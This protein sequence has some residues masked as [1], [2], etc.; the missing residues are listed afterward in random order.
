MNHPSHHAAP[1]GGLAQGPDF[2][3]LGNIAFTA[4]CILLIASAV[5]VIVSL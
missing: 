1:K 2:G 3:P 4:L 5:T